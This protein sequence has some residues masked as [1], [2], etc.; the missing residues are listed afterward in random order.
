MTIFK[1]IKPD[2]Y[3]LVHTFPDGRMERAELV[4]DLAELSYVW[5][6]WSDDVSAGLKVGDRFLFGGVPLKV[7]Q[8]RIWDASYV[9]MR[10]E[11]ASW[12]WMV[13]SWLWAREWSVLFRL[14]RW[15]IFHKFIAHDPAE[16][17]DRSWLANL[18][19]IRWGVPGGKTERCSRL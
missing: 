6:R 17:L 14:V 3:L 5:T 4:G 9:V 18:R 13:R 11:W 8:D 16:M 12:P 15:L 7:V 19:N 1:E 10:A 2:G